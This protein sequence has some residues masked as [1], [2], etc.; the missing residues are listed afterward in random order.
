MFGLLSSRELFY[1]LFSIIVI[2]ALVLYVWL[3][4]GDRLANSRESEVQKQLNGAAAGD[5]VWERGAVAISET[6]VLYWD[7]SSPSNS[8]W[9]IYDSKS[10]EV[11][12]GNYLARALDQAGPYRDALTN[13]GRL[14]GW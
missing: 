5:A 4:F 8:P 14:S 9:R 3:T 7:N 10:D 12:D 2:A 11:S 1:S 6:K 13:G